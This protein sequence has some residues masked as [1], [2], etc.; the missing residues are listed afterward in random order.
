M[1]ALTTRIRKAAPANRRASEDSLPSAKSAWTRATLPPRAARH[2]DARHCQRGACSEP[3][4]ATNDLC[5]AIGGRLARGGSIS[6]EA[7]TFIW[8]K[9]KIRAM[10]FHT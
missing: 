4:D 1:A 6:N 5:A 3:I 9:L 10:H 8:K 2:E 7:L